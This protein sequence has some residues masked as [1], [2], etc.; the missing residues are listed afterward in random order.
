MVV[1]RIIELFVGRE[2]RGECS[3]PLPPSPFVKGLKNMDT[4]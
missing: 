2:K 4:R 3:K 1:L